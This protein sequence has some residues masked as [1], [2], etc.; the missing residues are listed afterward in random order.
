MIRFVSLNL[1]L[2]LFFSLP[3]F[4]QKS[5]EEN[6][7]FITLKGDTIHGYLYNK[8]SMYLIYKNEKGKRKQFTPSKIKGFRINDKDYIPLYLK[9]F[10]SKR[11][12]AIKEK[13]YYTLLQYED[14]AKYGPQPFMG[15]AAFGA[16]QGSF[17]ARNSGYY[18]KKA[19]DENYYSVPS[20]KK[21]LISFL[22]IYFADDPPILEPVPEDKSPIDSIELIVRSYN[23]RHKRNE[24]VLVH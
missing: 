20:K 24:P 16:V 22:N 6:G 17:Q 12:M 8:E 3:A 2:I 5:Y 19:D 18:L 9:E 10:D 23:E 13:G 21:L 11:F 7:Y 15:G 14:V 1:F 4:C